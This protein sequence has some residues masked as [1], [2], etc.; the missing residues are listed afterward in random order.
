MSKHPVR[1]ARAE[2]AGNVPARIGDLL[3]VAA[4]TLYVTAFLYVALRRAAY[5]FDLEWMEGGMVESVRRILAGGPLYAAPSLDFVPFIYTPLFYYLSAGVSLV[6]GPGY[7]PLRL[8]A[9]ASTA[10]CLALLFLIVRRET[11]K[12][13]PAVC[14]A[15]LFAAAYPLSGCWY[16]IARCDTL[17]LALLLA[18]VYLIRFRQPGW[19]HVLAGILLVLSFLAKQA[20]LFITLPLAAYLV[21]RLRWRS[22]WLVGTALAGLVISTAVLDLAH[23]GWYRFY[24]FTLPGE[25]ALIF[26]HYTHFWATDIQHMIPSTVLA[27]LY[28]RVAGR[29]GKPGAMPLYLALLVGMLA[30][31]WASRA[32]EGGYVNVI[33]PATTGL[34]LVAG[35]ALATVPSSVGKSDRLRG[36]TN[37]GVILAVLVQFGLLF[38][39][40]N[41]EIPTRADRAAHEEVVAAVRQVQGDVFCPNHP[42]LAVQAGKPGFAHAQALSDI[43]R[44]KQ[45]AATRQLVAERE[46][47]LRS[48]RFQA[49]I[50]G[51]V[52]PPGAKYGA[53]KMADYYRLI[54]FPLFSDTGALHPKTG[55]D[56]RPIALYAFGA[57]SS[58]G[59]ERP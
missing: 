29:A 55:M 31:A 56:V 6:T 22:L 18:A 26:K 59:E 50:L 15:G 57:D 8:V 30:S 7:L 33:M 47:A 17:F 24:V 4:S 58:T 35:L 36:V 39:R 38:Y 27:V 37:A 19:P 53:D 23:H 1:P 40:P 10:A 46:S 14:A 20:A 28:F 44:S 2:G 48:G 54:R 11:G 13:V 51:Y 16:D 32:H 25:H 41:R 34:A 5:P 49:L 12:L 52:V 3:V 21:Y 9:I 42:Y 45:Q 43:T